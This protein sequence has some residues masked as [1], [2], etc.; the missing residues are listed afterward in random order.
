MGGPDGD[1][2][3]A[4]GQNT[5]DLAYCET[6][7]LAYLHSLVWNHMLHPRYC[8]NVWLAILF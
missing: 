4:C 8:S 2:M 7:L 3:V 1:G 5:L 6:S